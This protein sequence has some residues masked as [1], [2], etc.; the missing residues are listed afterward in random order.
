MYLPFLYACRATSYLPCYENGIV[1]PR[2]GGVDDAQLTSSTASP[3]IVGRLKKNLLRSKTPKVLLSRS[4]FVRASRMGWKT[5]SARLVASARS[6]GV[7]KG[8]SRR[9]GNDT[10]A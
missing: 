7:Q 3:R 6:E 4:A 1:S 8:P 5:A 2:N 10:H 9:G